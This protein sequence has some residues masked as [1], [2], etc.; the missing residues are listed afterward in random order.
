MVVDGEVG[1]SSRWE[2]EKDGGKWW[3][4]WWIALMVEILG[5]G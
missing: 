1:N 4:R 2:Q 5:S 3:Q